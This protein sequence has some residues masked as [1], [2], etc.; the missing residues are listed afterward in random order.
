MKKKVHSHKIPKPSAKT[1]IHYNVNLNTY[2]SD[3]SLLLQILVLM[4]HYVDLPWL[5][6]RRHLVCLHWSHG[7]WVKI[8]D[9]G[10]EK[11]W[12][13]VLV[14]PIITCMFLGIFFLFEPQFPDVL[15]GNN[16]RFCLLALGISSP[17]WYDG[18]EFYHWNGFR[19]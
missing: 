15:N 6:S 19:N 3:W 12:V 18:G 7:V 8:L 1:I 16:K 13:S 5:N 4:G 10:K 17:I 9:F 11:R 2:L 14:C